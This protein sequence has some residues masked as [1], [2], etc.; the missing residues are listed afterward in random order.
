MDEHI[1]KVKKDGIKANKLHPKE[2]FLRKDDPHMMCEFPHAVNLE[3]ASVVRLKKNET[4][5]KLKLEKKM[6]LALE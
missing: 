4:V 3:T 2:F 5:R 6:V 1:A